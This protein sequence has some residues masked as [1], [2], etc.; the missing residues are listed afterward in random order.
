MDR[1][2]RKEE[3]KGAIE[4]RIGRTLVKDLEDNKLE[5]LEESIF[6]TISVVMNCSWSVSGEEG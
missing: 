6:E 2:G 3:R 4:G 5:E 1:I